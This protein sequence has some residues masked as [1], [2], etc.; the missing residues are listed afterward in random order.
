MTRLLIVDDER[1][2]RQ[3]IRYAIDWEL[4]GIE[5]VG[6]AANGQDAVE[7]VK[8]YSPDIILTDVVMPVI[9]GVEF[10]RI[11]RSMVPD[12]Y[13]IILSAYSD[14][15][16]MQQ[17]VGVGVNDYLLKDADASDILNAAKK[18]KE[19]IEYERSRFLRENLRRSVWNDFSPAIRD[20]L[21]RRIVES[22]RLVEGFIDVAKTLD[23]NIGGPYY[24]LAL[25]NAK[26]AD[27]RK[28]AA[29]LEMSLAAYRPVVAV[30]RENLV[31]ILISV[32][33]KEDLSVI[34]EDH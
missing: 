10:S 15:D 28:I 19:F 32:S 3:G 20:E 4:H 8:E 13:I 12:V 17:A 21:F 27:T 11:A 2:F 14:P 6:E 25:C 23:V 18:G 1:P 16:W 29:T 5:V 30:F 22:N 31:A 24:I 26:A 33:Q 7:M 9:D 34:E